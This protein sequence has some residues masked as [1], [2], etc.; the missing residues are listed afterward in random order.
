MSNAEGQV[1]QVAEIDVTEVD[2]AQIAVCGQAWRYAEDS[3]NIVNQ[4]HL[5]IEL[6]KAANYGQ[7]VE[8][9]MGEGFYASLFFRP[10]GTVIA[11][12][13]HPSPERIDRATEL[14]DELDGNDAATDAMAAYCL[15]IIAENSSSSDISLLAR[16]VEANAARTS[17]AE[18]SDLNA[19]LGIDIKRA[20]TYF[21]L[22]RTIGAISFYDQGINTLTT[23]ADYR[24]GEVGMTIATGLVAHELAKIQHLPELRAEL[25]NLVIN[26]TMAQPCLGGDGLSKILPQLSTEERDRLIKV[27]LDRKIRID[28]YPTRLMVV[29]AADRNHW[30]GQRQIRQEWSRLNRQCSDMTRPGCDPVAM[31]GV[32]WQR[33]MMGWHDDGLFLSPDNLDLATYDVRR[34]GVD[35]V[36]GYKRESLIGRIVS[37]I[38][39]DRFSTAEAETFRHVLRDLWSTSKDEEEKLGLSFYLMSLDGN[40]EAFRHAT[41]TVMAQEVWRKE[42]VL[43]HANGHPARPLTNKLSSY[44]NGLVLFRGLVQER[45]GLHQPFLTPPESIYDFGFDSI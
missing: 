7:A 36:E 37:G 19:E 20:T 30:L 9:L 45:T 10:I 27:Y 14:V 42:S 13:Q 33:F 17:S 34:L 31:T 25:V 12:T 39:A 32:A 41:N 1:G 2:M 40:V 23:E 3:S 22:A 24:Y 5:G 43:A 35:G 16:A 6:V 44:L 26:Q 15:S 21:R 4:L 38:E 29:E 18:G 11:L 8:Y 28:G